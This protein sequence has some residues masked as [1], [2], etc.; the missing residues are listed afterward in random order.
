[1]MLARMHCVFP[2]KACELVWLQLSRLP[3]PPASQSGC[4]CGH[5]DLRR[6]S[7][8]LQL[9][10]KPKLIFSRFIAPE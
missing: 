5:M 6:H 10:P 7:R 1:M 9:K 3:S 4:H 2:D 8:P